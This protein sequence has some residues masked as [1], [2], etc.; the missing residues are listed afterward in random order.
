MLLSWN[1][2]MIRWSVHVWLTTLAQVTAGAG[3][4]QDMHL[5]PTR[6]HFWKLGQSWSHRHLDRHQCRLDN[7]ACLKFG[8]GHTPS[9]AAGKKTPQWQW[10]EDVDDEVE[11]RVLG[12][13]VDILGTNCDQCRS[14][15]QCCFMSTETVRLIRTESPGRPPRLSHSSWT[16]CEDVPLVK[17]IYVPCTYT[18]SHAKRK[19]IVGDSGLCCCVC[20]VFQRLINSLRLLYVTSFKGWLTPFV[21]CM[22]RLSR[23]D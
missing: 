8:F 21:C 6:Q 10:C 16:L 15:V 23:A 9:S 19:V 3:F 20:D 2:L 4:T 11:L 12:C 22:W 13:R 5:S 1:I 17:F 14:T 18:Y 7:S